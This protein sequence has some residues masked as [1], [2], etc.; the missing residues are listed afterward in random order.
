[1][2]DIKIPKYL[3]KT[4]TGLTFLVSFAALA[5]SPPD[6]ALEAAP[7]TPLQAVPIAPETLILNKIEAELKE[8][9]KT[10]I[11]TSPPIQS[12]M[13]T[14][15]QQSLLR[16]AKNGFSVDINEAGE[17]R[18]STSDLT[19]AEI[20]EFRAKNAISSVRKI[21]LGGIVFISP[22]D[23]TIWLNKK[24]ITP[25]RIPKEVLDLR[26]SKEFVELRWL[27]AQENK[28]YP[29]R[30]RPNQTFNLDAKIFTPG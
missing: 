7:E 23:W 12:L 10:E 2:I 17:R 1:M 4:L 24:L 21:S 8:K 18:E 15:T 30:L 16:E 26:V 13:F 9:Y 5:Q 3:L 20:E 29:V 27:D 25:G 28:I 11:Y 14:P 19:P 6:A 22:N